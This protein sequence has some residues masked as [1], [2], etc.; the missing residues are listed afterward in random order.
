[1]PIGPSG[2]D[3]SDTEEQQAQVA[4]TGP[5]KGLHAGM[6]IAAKA[7]IV[8]FVV[9]TV[10]NVDFASGIYTAVRGWIESTLT[11]YYITVALVMLFVCF[12]LLFS[13][14]GSIRLGDDDS[15]P[16]FKNFGAG[17]A[18]GFRSYVCPLA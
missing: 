5:M 16:E 10:L 12:Y 4:T 18:M 15:R 13:R 6:G 7:M 17:L 9:F 14:F 11:W 2:E 1:M 3:M 8:S